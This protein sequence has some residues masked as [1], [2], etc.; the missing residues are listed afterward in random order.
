MLKITEPAGQT[1][2]S[3]K[4]QQSTSSSEID[5]TS[6]FEGA[7]DLTS[8]E[9]TL[10]T[11]SDMEADM[12]IRLSEVFVEEM[13]DAENYYVMGF[14]LIDNTNSTVSYIKEEHDGKLY[15]NDSILSIWKRMRDKTA[16]ISLENIDEEET[17]FTVELKNKELTE[18]IKIFQKLLNMNDH[19]G[20]RTISE[21]CQKFADNLI[22]MGTHY[23][24]VHAETI[25]RALVRKK[26]NNLEM[27]DFTM[28]GDPRD[29]EILKLDSALLSNPSVLVSMSYGYLKKQIIGAE[30]YEKT[31]PSHLDAFAVS[32]L[33]EYI[34][35]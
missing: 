11:D 22:A 1:V 10:K 34:N 35:Q 6:G 32:R 14:E 13:D 4:H 3:A 33:S 24:L 26:S 28:K 17:L 7:F 2:L 18:P 23:D 5:F 8:N 30:L 29:V 19:M 31:A 16:P 20:A 21:I 9:V 12:S 27:P 15:L 25:I